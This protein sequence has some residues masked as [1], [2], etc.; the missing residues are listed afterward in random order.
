[1]FVYNYVGI[2]LAQHTLIPWRSHTADSDCSW[3][4]FTLYFTARRKS[5][6]GLEGANRCVRV[7]RLH[8]SPVSLRDWA[9]KLTWASLR[10]ALLP[11]I[12]LD[13]FVGFDL[14]KLR[15]TFKSRLQQKPCDHQSYWYD[16]IS[17]N[18]TGDNNHE[19]WADS[20][21]EGSRLIG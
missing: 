1:M 7:L 12:F 20:S 21:S 19:Q 11:E 18:K 6:K 9:G 17:R 4:E 16:N 10:A 3:G 13:V 5:A 15:K 14:T 8:R 2:S